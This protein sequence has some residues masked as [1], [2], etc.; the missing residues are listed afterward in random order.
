M[1]AGTFVTESF[2]PGAQS[3][4]VLCREKTHTPACTQTHPQALRVATCCTPGLR[5]KNT[6]LPSSAPCLRTAAREQSVV[7]VRARLRLGSPSRDLQSTTRKCLF[8]DYHESQ[9][10][11]APARRRSRGVG[12]GN[13]RPRRAKLRHRPGT[14]ATSLPPTSGASHSERARRLRAPAPERSDP[15]GGLT[16]SAPRGRPAP[17]VPAGRGTHLTRN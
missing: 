9:E 6:H 11:T 13:R 14:R 4:E 15:R 8:G 17:G 7:R 16:P 2:L 12:M 5:T 1:K 10:P 3:T